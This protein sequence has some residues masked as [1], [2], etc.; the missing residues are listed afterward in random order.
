MGSV[1]L[2]KEGLRRLSASPLGAY[3][4]ISISDLAERLLCAG[5]R[6]YAIQLLQ[7]TATCNYTHP[8]ILS[9]LKACQQPA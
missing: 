1:E 6:G 8:R 7:S 5:Q 4:S 3:L 9:L 2:F